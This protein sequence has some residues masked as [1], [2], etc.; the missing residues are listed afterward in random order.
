[1]QGRRTGWS[2]ISRVDQDNKAAGRRQCRKQWLTVQEGRVPATTRSVTELSVF[3]GDFSVCIKGR[4][5]RE[6]FILHS[7]QYMTKMALQVI[8]V[9]NRSGVWRFSIW[10]QRTPTCR[11]SLYRSLEMLIRS[12][13]LRRKHSWLKWS[14]SRCYCH[15]N[16]QHAIIDVTH[17]I[18]FPLSLLLTRYRR[19]SSGRQ[20]SSMQFELSRWNL[21]SFPV[22][23]FESV[24]AY[25]Q[26]LPAANVTRWITCS[27]KI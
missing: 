18:E 1:M 14:M 25:A 19:G 16:L 12:T 22:K 4:N 13:H 21:K 24:W 20:P 27:L 15:A 8:D 2:I 5:N 6:K 10:A 9:V 17:H 7:M 3:S 23:F 26:Q 11:A